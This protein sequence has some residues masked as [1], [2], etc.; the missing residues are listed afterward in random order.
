MLPGSQ[1]SEKNHLP[2]TSIRI[3]LLKWQVPFFHSLTLTSIF[4]SKVWHFS[5]F[6]NIS[7]TMR[8]RANNTISIR[9]G[10]RYLTWNGGTANILRNEHGLYF[11]EAR[12]RVV[13]SEAPT[14]QI[15]MGRYKGVL[16]VEGVE[17]GPLTRFL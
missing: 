15:G 12:R 6:A 4:N 5:S 3:F 10:V 14:T 17:Q 1:N 11:Q 8:D 16:V 13:S 2:G 7:S 9:Q